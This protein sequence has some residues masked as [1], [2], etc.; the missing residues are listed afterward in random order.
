MYFVLK[1]YTVI[2]YNVVYILVLFSEIYLKKI[3]HFLRT[4]SP[5]PSYLS[6]L[7]C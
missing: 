2:E 1:I 5:T 4:I 7:D 6:Y 3:V